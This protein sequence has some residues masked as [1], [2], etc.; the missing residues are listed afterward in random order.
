[1]FGTLVL[2]LELYGLKLIQIIDKSTGT[3]FWPHAWLY[4]KEAPIPIAV[5]ITVCIIIAG[6]VMMFTKDK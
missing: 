1:M 5:M 4:L 3:S 2:S 6:V